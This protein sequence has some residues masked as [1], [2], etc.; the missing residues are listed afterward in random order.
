MNKKYRNTSFLV[1]LL[2]N[3]LVF[4][5]SCAIIV[6][7]FGKASE[8]TRNTREKSYA[9]AEIYA[10]FEEFRGEGLSA[11]DDGL[12]EDGEVLYF[13]D[14]NWNLTEADDLAKYVVTLRVEPQRELEDGTGAVG[15]LSRLIAS[16][17]ESNGREICTLET[18]V[19]QAEKGVA[20]DG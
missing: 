3:V 17:Q 2:I 11:L 6:G 19:Y 18:S 15:E 13:Y 20:A 12:E 10:V 8:V 7:V 16:A 1:E 4:S 5:V 14:G 9:T